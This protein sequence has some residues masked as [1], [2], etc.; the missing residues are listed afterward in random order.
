VNICPLFRK[1]CSLECIKFLSIMYYWCDAISEFR[2]DSQLVSNAHI[3]WREFFLSIVELVRWIAVKL[4]VVLAFSI[5]MNRWSTQ[6][7]WSNLSHLCRSL[8]YILRGNLD[9]ILSFF[10]TEFS[11]CSDE[12]IYFIDTLRILLSVNG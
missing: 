3:F 4:L 12:L 6:S 2:A 7:E 1:L 8:S 11:S 5:S 9:F 10:E